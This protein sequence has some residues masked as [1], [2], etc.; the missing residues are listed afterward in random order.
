MKR[1]FTF[2]IF[3]LLALASTL[4]VI[5]FVGGT[6]VH[7]QDITSDTTWFEADNPHHVNA[8]ITVTS[9]NTLTIEAGCNVYFD[10]GV[11]LIVEGTLEAK[12]TYGSRIN[13][14]ANSTSPYR[15][16]WDGIL[17][18]DTSIDCTL[19]YCNVTWARIGC[20]VWSKNRINITRSN[21][22]FNYESAIAGHDGADMNIAFN[23]ITY[24]YNT[25]MTFSMPSRAIACYDNTYAAIQNNNITDNANQADMSGSFYGI[26]L[27]RSSQALIANNTISRNNYTGDSMGQS[28]GIYAD[29]N[30]YAN[31]LNNLI[32]NNYRGVY[33]LTY[34]TIDAVGNDLRY[35]NWALFL[36]RGNVTIINNEFTDNNVGIYCRE[37]N[38]TIEKNNITLC[39]SQGMTLQQGG[40]YSVLDV[41][42]NNVTLTAYENVFT[43]QNFAGIQVIGSGFGGNEM[44][45]LIEN[46]NV[47]YNNDT[48]IYLRDAVVT[49]L[50]NNISNNGFNLN[51]GA[52]ALGST[53]P[54]LYVNN[55][56][57]VV[58]ENDIIHANAI[59]VFCL[60]NAHPVIIN[61]TLDNSTRKDIYLS[62]SKA[63]LVNTGVDYDEVHYVNPS[64]EL[65]AA[66]FVH[67]NVTHLTAG[68]P[69]TDVTIKDS[70]GITIS[71]GTTNAQGNVEYLWFLNMSISD[72]NADNVGSVATES[73]DYNPHNFTCLNIPLMYVGF[74]EVALT[75]TVWVNV[76]ME[77]VSSSWIFWPNGRVIVGK[78]TYTDKIIICSGDVIITPN[79]TLEFTRVF[80]G[81]SCD[82]DGQYAIQTNQTAWFNMTDSTI[83]RY[84]QGS[85]G[86][87]FDGFTFGANGTFENATINGLADD[88]I[89]VM[90]SNNVQIMNS[91]VLN[92][93]A[94]GI[95]IDNSNTFVYNTTVTNTGLEDSMAG[96]IEIRGSS[97]A[98]IVKNNVSEGSRYGIYTN[99]GMSCQIEFNTVW[100]HT[101]GI[102][103]QSTPADVNR[104]IVHDN[105]YGIYISGSQADVNNN[106][107]YGNDYGIYISSSD[108]ASVYY[109]NVRHQRLFGIYLTSSDCRVYHNTIKD[110]GKVESTAGYGG[111]YV[112]NSYANIQYN[113]VHHNPY[114]GIYVWNWGDTPFT[115]AN[116][117]LTNNGYNNTAM[118]YI[119][120]A[121]LYISWATNPIVYGN[122]VTGNKMGISLQDVTNPIVTNSTIT[123]SSL[124]DLIIFD[125]HAFFINCTVG[126]GYADV[127]FDPAASI[128]QQNYVDARVLKNGAPEPSA[129][130]EVWEGGF[131]TITRNVDANGW[132]Y[133]MPIT[134]RTVACTSTNHPVT[135]WAN[136]FTN[137]HASGKY[138]NFHQNIGVY[139]TTPLTLTFRNYDPIQTWPIPD[140]YSV[141]EDSYVMQLIDLSNYFQSDRNITAPFVYSVD[142]NSASGIIDV[143]MHTDGRNLTVD[144]STGAAND[145]WHGPVTLRMKATDG[146]G[147]FVL[148]NEFTIKINS[149]NDK[150]IWDPIGPLYLTEDVV[151]PYL[152]DLEDYIND[153][154]HTF[155]KLSFFIPVYTHS[156]Y[157]DLYINN[158]TYL[159]IKPQAGVNNFYDTIEATL[160]AYDGIDNAYLNVTIYISPRNDAPLINHTIEAVTF[161]ED[162][163]DDSV[164]LA[165]IFMDP[166]N[167]PLTFRNDPSENINV[168]IDGAGKV[169]LTPKSNWFGSDTIRFYANDT[170]AEAYYDVD[171]VVLNVN[172]PPTMQSLSAQTFKEGTMK[173][174]TLK[175]TDPDQESLTYS[176]NILEN[177]PGLMEEGYF[178]FD[179]E[180]GL[181]KIEADDVHVGEY[182]MTFTVTDPQGESDSIKVKFR[183]QDQNEAPFGV[184]IAYP[185]NGTSVFFGTAIELR[186]RCTDPD[187]SVPGGNEELT[188]TWESNLTEL[189]L[190]KGETL[191]NVVLP[192]GLNKITLTVE[193]RG[194][195]KV[196]A[197]IVVNSMNA[198]KDSDGDGIADE[199]DLDDDNDGMPDEWEELYDL[200]PLKD[201]AG[202][203]KDNDGHTNF[204]EYINSTD[205]SDPNSPIPPEPVDDDDDDTKDEGSI[206]PL[207][208]ILAVIVIVGIIIVVVVM[209]VMRKKK[210]PPAEGPEPTPVPE[211]TLLEPTPVGAAKPMKGR[212]EPIHKESGDEQKPKLGT[213]PEQEQLQGEDEQKL[214]PEHEEGPPVSEESPVDEEE[215]PVTEE[216]GSP[217]PE[218]GLTE[219][220]EAPVEE[221]QPPV[222]EIDDSMFSLEDEE[223]PVTDESPVPEV[224]D[225]AQG[226][227][228]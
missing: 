15:G 90:S 213:V 86:L 30:S 77:D 225:M 188:F 115:I 27:T 10:T 84:S 44:E 31:L 20:D 87:R 109:N 156:E 38:G 146:L 211:R 79:S 179:S 195:L 143:K 204:E 8:T 136:N 187:L 226:P 67:V 47:S 177:I 125:C 113:T 118:S 140:T 35:A 45:V 59:N 43:S 181:C 61:S 117:Q 54:G 128:K 71:S 63:T 11:Q 137:N 199:F 171:V 202:R 49:M 142:Y 158:N 111:I 73:T 152:V 91:T 191:S 64:C 193:D 165:Y 58:S 22:S 62:S 210:K 2:L 173:E 25:S 16:F 160:R 95:Y 114:T 220:G 180:T 107:A 184:E 83:E 5:G 139:P 172:D 103:T 104:N 169:T 219:E 174:F 26:Y 105:Q 205:P 120:Y 36:N 99:T 123:G 182:D 13:F 98:V 224:E 167:D 200:D 82:S 40:Y 164:D 148:S 194:G 33:S 133:L 37:V 222:E 100:N 85:F 162:T 176:S 48:G 186:G 74:K 70:R 190:G 163:V 17:F 101:Y 207:L 53:P 69:D 149:I 159:A 214:L 212:P 80:M 97:Q 72:Q 92:C 21:L 151:N 147:N 50:N 218:E 14:T 175:A 153:A 51:L 57:V 116:N 60:G 166:E 201:D 46:N 141:D 135:T 41:L 12:G 178:L 88:G 106:T 112:S 29:R 206:L 161:K 168:F 55:A 155:S 124:G 65:I 81:M 102:Y 3:L 227:P 18:K 223:S 196:S 129:T 119:Q 198:S 89:E 52:I 217:V 150:P 68:V 78:E 93:D 56:D 42:D 108:M 4:A 66:D 7:Y 1:M 192:E 9:G 183:I 94:A 122:T 203:D 6:A 208:G 215:S 145:N 221:E 32:D 132:T 19:D 76:E 130:V 127:T 170:E 28:A 126:T 228:E 144:A 216:D 185:A 134:Y 39:F 75:K 154:D 209:V 96:G 131:Q 23:N 121:G 157:M 189:E 34:A 110:N 138:T 24:N 197:W